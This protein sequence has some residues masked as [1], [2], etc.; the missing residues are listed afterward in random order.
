MKQALAIA[1]IAAGLNMFGAP[2]VPDIQPGRSVINGT[3]IF[4][5]DA[6]L[7]TDGQECW[8]DPDLSCSE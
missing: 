1:A 4:V 7:P 3:G 6:R 8:F 5:A 2:T